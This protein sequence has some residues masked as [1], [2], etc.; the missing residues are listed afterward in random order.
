M[1]K[2]MQKVIR[3]SVVR[4]VCL[5]LS[6]ACLIR[7]ICILVASCIFKL[8][9][10]DFNNTLVMC[11]LA[12]DAIIFY[13]LYKYFKNVEFID[14]ADNH[15]SELAKENEYISMIVAVHS[16]LICQQFCPE[17]IKKYQIRLDET[18]SYLLD[19]EANIEAFKELQDTEEITN[20]FIKN[21]CV[22]DS[23]ISAWKITTI[24]PQDL[25]FID[26]LVV[27]NSKLAVCVALSLMDLSY[28]EL[29][30]NRYVKQLIELLAI[31]YYNQDY[32]NTTII[33]LESMILELLH[34]NLNQ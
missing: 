32:G 26:D 11:A 24:I 13:L 5:V 17:F 16:K 15:I 1:K 4:S 21:A 33:E 31:C 14:K 6:V 22:M 28:D 20:N 23:L 29:K 27:I 19:Y 8:L 18:N 2:L 25:V 34:N 30:D 3:K 10:H 9:P 12:I 7:A